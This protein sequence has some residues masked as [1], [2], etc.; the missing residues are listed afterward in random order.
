[1]S[2]GPL[3]IA[4]VGC[5]SVLGYY[6]AVAEKLR[7]RGLA[8]I[9]AVCDVDDSKRAV[10]REQ[11]GLHSFTTDYRDLV[12]RGDIDLVMVLT[13][14]LWHGPVTRA[15]LQAGKHVYVEKPL[16]LRLDAASRHVDPE[17][18]LEDAQEIV[19]LAK[20][21]RLFLACAPFVVLSSTYQAMWRRIHAGEIGRVSSARAVYGS[22][23]PSSPW[24][25]EAGGGPLFNIGIYN[26]T[27]MTGLL[28]P[29]RRVMAMTGVAL[30]ER[31]VRGQIVH[32]AADEDNAQLLLDF[33]DATLGVVTT[34]WALQRIHAPAIEVYGTQGTIQMLGYDWAPDGYE[35]WHNDE[36]AWRVY[37]E[38]DAGW[39]WADGLRHFV[40][41]LHH[42]TP[43][44]A[45]LDHALHV[46]EIILKAK[47]ASRDG[48]VKEIQSTFKP[49]DLLDWSL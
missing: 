37:P 42:D 32:Y 11:F 7:Q 30:P 39:S 13:A 33:G 23:M 24:C 17:A 34:G 12:A 20:N 49:E 3:R 1:M 47:A 43:P 5:G 19:A 41:C 45:M 4:F 38:S 36:R 28:G 8:E 14:D 18:T 9:V 29:V 16:T 35:L 22:N 2:T 31:T 21:R 46:L 26:V 27:S 10:V 25:Y 15:A 40:E 48:V 44:E 6:V